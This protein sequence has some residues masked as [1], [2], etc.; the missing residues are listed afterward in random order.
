MSNGKL[1]NLIKDDLVINDFSMEID[2]YIEDKHLYVDLSFSWKGT[3]ISGKLKKFSPNNSYDPYLSVI[4][5]HWDNICDECIEIYELISLYHNIKSRDEK[6]LDGMMLH[7]FMDLAESLLDNFPPKEDLEGGIRDHRFYPLTGISH[8]LRAIRDTTEDFD[9][10]RLDRFEKYIHE[11]HKK[12]LSA[13]KLFEKATGIGDDERDLQ[14][15]AGESEFEDE[16]DWR[17]KDEDDVSEKDGDREIEPWEDEDYDPDEEREDEVDNLLENYVDN[18]ADFVRA[19]NF[20]WMEAVE[21]ISE[22]QPVTENTEYIEKM[23][24]ARDAVD[25]AYAN[26]KQATE[27]MAIAVFELKPLYELLEDEKRGPMARM[28][29][30]ISLASRPAQL[31]KV[32]KEGMQKERGL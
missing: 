21:K 4:K 28:D 2:T 31:E 14:L 22:G 5:H 32:I 9:R 7:V 16:D 12:S 19:A 10:I 30:L 23:K 18:V 1:E 6:I 3:I 25:A 20:I 17:D 8:R 27:D 26:F 11:V 24:N 15:T 29:K 13:L